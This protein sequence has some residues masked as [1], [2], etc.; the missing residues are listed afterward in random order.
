MPLTKIKCPVCEG[1]N[2]ECKVCNGHLVI[3]RKGRNDFL[4]TPPVNKGRTN[5][6]KKT[7]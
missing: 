7:D 6:S 5:E 4:G 2:Y 3:W 1:L